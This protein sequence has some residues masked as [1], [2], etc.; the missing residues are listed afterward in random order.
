MYSAVL[1]FSLFDR[2]PSL[3]Y[4]IIW[5][6]CAEKNLSF[7]LYNHANVQN[8]QPVQ[9]CSGFRDCTFPPTVINCNSL[10]Q[11]IMLSAHLWTLLPLHTFDYNYIKDKSLSDF[12][13]CI[14]NVGTSQFWCGIWS[15]FEYLPAWF[16]ALHRTSQNIDTIILV[17]MW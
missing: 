17:I 10:L 3:R 15:Q 7:L 2:L 9:F 1:A 4:Y 6:H 5:I 13:H 16:S 11:P 12:G 14:S 8:M